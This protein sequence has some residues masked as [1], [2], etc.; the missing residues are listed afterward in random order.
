MFIHWC[1]FTF[2]FEILL[3]SPL[4]S[5]FPSSLRSSNPLKVWFKTHGYGDRR[6]TRG[7]RRLSIISPLFLRVLHLEGCNKLICCFS[8]RCISSGNWKRLEGWKQA[9]AP[10]CTHNKLLQARF[11]DFIEILISLIREAPRRCFSCKQEK[12]LLV[13]CAVILKLIKRSERVAKPLNS[14]FVH[15]CFRR[16]IVRNNCSLTRLLRWWCL[17]NCFN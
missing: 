12:L 10:V 2:D 5:L 7:S 15:S 11:R 4:C 16:G 3:P 14:R 8:R 13:N 6:V 1:L 17:L 9:F